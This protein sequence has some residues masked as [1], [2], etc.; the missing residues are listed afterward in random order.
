MEVDHIQEECHVQ[1]IQVL[2]VDKFDEC[3]EEATG[4]VYLSMAMV[5]P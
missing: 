1:P 4:K 5:S 2:R 3:G